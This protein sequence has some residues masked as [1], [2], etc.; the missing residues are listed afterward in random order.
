MSFSLHSRLLFILIFTAGVFP[1]AAASKTTM[2]N[3]A[4][5]GPTCA[6]TS[7]AMLVYWFGENGYPKLLPERGTPQE[8]QSQVIAEIT[9]ACQTSS[10]SG[11]NGNGMAGKLMAYFRSHGYEATVTQRCIYWNQP[12]DLQWLSQNSKDNTGFIL[13]ISYAVRTG[14]GHYMFTLDEGHSVT[15]ESGGVPT[16]IIHDPAHWQGQ[17]GRYSVKI[18]PIPDATFSIKSRDIPLPFLYEIQ[19]V[20]IPQGSTNISILNSIICIEMPVPESGA[21][22]K[23]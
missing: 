13:W 21:S 2:P 5:Q 10:F 19:G 6:P 8:K 18:I 20:P 9:R 14:L 12:L 11:T 17:T 15:L 16:A 7:I 23:S 22:P 4:Q 1:A 3:F